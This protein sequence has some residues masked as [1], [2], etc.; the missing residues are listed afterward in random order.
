[1]VIVVLVAIQ[2]L[3]AVFEPDLAMILLITAGTTVVTGTVLW[4]F[5]RSVSA[6]KDLSPG[7]VDDP[8]APRSTPPMASEG[9]AESCILASAS[10]TTGWLD[11][12]HGELWVC[13]DGL[14]RRSLGLVKT[15]E[16]G[17]AATVDPRSRPQRR[18]TA[19]E[20]YVQSNAGGTNRWVG[21]DWIDSAE[22][23]RGLL[24]DSFHYRLKNGSR[25][26]L[27]WFRTDD[28]KDL[29]EHAARSNLGARLLAT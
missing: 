25:G 3:S 15:M 8:D 26:K 6:N 9:L 1:M 21:W 12:I 2:V 10:C 23:R 29:I 27:L 5:F 13:P 14:L 19:A 18:I 20:K 17:S 7:A 24:T 11:W 22:V 16:H 28:A 4:F